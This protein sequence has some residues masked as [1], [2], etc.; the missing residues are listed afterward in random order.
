MA[1]VDPVGGGYWVERHLY[2]TER[3]LSTIAYY[4]FV[5][6]V[7]GGVK[8]VIGGA[9]LITAV[10]LTIVFF[11]PACFS[12]D[13]NAFWQRSFIHI[14]HG[15]GNVFSGLIEAIPGIGTGIYAI[16]VAHMTS[17]KDKL[18]K[19]A[20]DNN[21]GAHAI[22]INKEMFEQKVEVE[23][24]DVRWVTGEAMPYVNMFERGDV[25][26]ISLD[27]EEEKRLNAIFL[28]ELAKAAAPL[29]IEIK[30]TIANSVIYPVPY[31]V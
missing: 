27:A 29:T 18:I 20:T 19:R 2:Q 23:G 9:Q 8:V 17:A 4:P 5:G 28:H 14:K 11:I 10:F 15:A 31:P 12:A 21:R 7:A 30:K 13:C 25:I 24:E 26:I 6:T 3:K 22:V 1:F 16:R